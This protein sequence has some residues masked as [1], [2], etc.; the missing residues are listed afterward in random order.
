MPTLLVLGATSDIALAIARK[1]ARHQYDIQLAGRDMAQLETIKTD[2]AIRNNVKTS[3][4]RFDA[5]DFSAHESF[6]NS[7]PVKP[8]ITVCVLGSMLDEEKAIDDWNTSRLMIETN[9]SGPVSILNIVARHYAAQKAGTIIGIS[10]VAGERGRQSKMIYGSSKAAFTAY[11]A[12]LRNK[13]FADKVHVMTVKPGFVYTKMTADIKLPPLLTA[14][15]EQVADAV[16][17]GAMKKKNTIYVK[18]FWR[19]IMLIIKCIPEF[20]FKKMKL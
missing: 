6:F 10:S 18:W 20:Q 3:V 7:L 1:F 4:H 11:L 5:L 14:Q 17:K 2:I 15:P 8:D 12:G 9:Y 13:L 16:Y 19:W